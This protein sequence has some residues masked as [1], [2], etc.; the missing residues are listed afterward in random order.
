M[1]DQA[2]T[3]AQTLRIANRAISAELAGLRTANSDLEGLRTANSDLE[4]ELRGAQGEVQ[5]LRTAN[6]AITAEVAALRLV[7]SEIHALRGAGQ[8]MEAELVAT[9]G[10]HA[11]AQS[12]RTAN[13]AMVAE[14]AGLRTANSDLM[15]GL[16]IANS[17]LEGL[18]NA[19]SAGQAVESGAVV[20]MRAEAQ[21]LRSLNERQSQEIEGLRTA[22][23]AMT[24][25]L[26]GLRTA[27]SGATCEGGAKRCRECEMA[28]DESKGRI[29]E[30]EREG[31]EYGAR[32]TSLN[33]TIELL[34][35]LLKEGGGAV[36]GKDG[37]D[38]SGAGPTRMRGAA[39]GVSVEEDE[40]CQRLRDEVGSLEVAIAAAKK[41]KECVEERVRELVTAEEEARV[42]GGV[43]DGQD[44]GVGGGEQCSR[45]EIEARSGSDRRPSSAG[46]RSGGQGFARSGP[47]QG[48]RG[49]GGRQGGVPR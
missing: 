22:N 26:A 34:G 3:E 8:G 7:N 1:L 15:E 45:G 35:R 30:L 48:A 44:Q 19:N 10:A 23:S 12:L 5:S 13:S 28:L 42:G 36:G 2:C 31:V 39:G 25:E 9:R 21:N 27:N 47:D 40:E 32:V 41:E 24:A 4:A 43:D 29:A 37:E 14:L 38:L 11:E 17:E 16:R 33:A 18:R 49:G 46:G 20:E 6:S